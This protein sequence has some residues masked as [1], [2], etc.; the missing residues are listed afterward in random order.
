[1]ELSKVSASVLLILVAILST[2]NASATVLDY[3]GPIT[4]G[5]GDFGY[6]ATIPE[7]S[8]TYGPT[9]TVGRQHVLNIFSL[10]LYKNTDRTMNLR[11]YVA[12]WDGGKATSIL[13][14]SPTVGVEAG[15]D[16]QEFKFDTGHLN[17]ASGKQYV[18]PFGSRSR[19]TTI[20]GVRHA[21]SR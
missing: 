3:S 11:G 5:I 21:L 14:T 8:T 18:I 15:S 2:A 7:V 13:Y 9:I 12:G 16:I 4:L 1:M 17:L 20:C 19:P 6:S 10:Y